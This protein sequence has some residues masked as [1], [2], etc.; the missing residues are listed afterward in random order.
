MSELY[1][2]TKLVEELAE[3]RA[4]EMMRAQSAPISF[5]DN[6]IRLS[7]LTGASGHTFE[8]SALLKEVKGWVAIGIGAVADRMSGLSLGAYA[9]GINGE[10]DELLPMQHR[11]N[12][13]MEDPNPIFSMPTMLG[14]SA[15]WLHLTGQA[16]FQVLHDGLG[17]PRELWPMPPDRVF[18]VPSK[19]NVIGGYVVIGASGAEI[20]METR[21]VVRV[22]RPDPKD[23]YQALGSLSPQATEFN[24]ERYRMGHVEKTYRNDATPRLVLESGEDAQLPTDLE[25]EAWGLKWREQYHRRSGRDQGVPAML[26]PGFKAHELGQTSDGA[27]TVDMGN[28]LRDQMLSSMGVPGSIVGLVQDVNRAAAETNQYTFDKNGVKPK[29][30]LFAG[31]MTQQLAPQFDPGI[32]YKFEEFLS[33]DKEFLLK[34]EDSDLRNKVR[35]PNEV[36]GS[37]G[38]DDA[39]WG[40]DPVGS[41]NDVPYT[42][43]DDSGMESVADL[44]G[45]PRQIP[46]IVSRSNDRA[47]TVTDSMRDGFSPERSWQRV[48]ANERKFVARFARGMSV[49]FKAQADAAVERF[50]K[51]H[52]VPRARVFADDLFIEGEFGELYLAEVQRV[53]ETIYV[54]NAIAAFGI[55]SSSAEFIFVDEQR[56]ILEA[57]HAEMVQNVDRVTKDRITRALVEGTGKGESVDQ[58]AKRISGAVI[59]RKRARTIARTE[60]GGAAQL[61]QIE[62]FA[63]SGVVDGKRWNTSFNN[64][65]D[66]HIAAHGQEVRLEELFL[67]G[68]ETASAPLSP[69][70]SAAQRANC[71][72]F[73]TPVFVDDGEGG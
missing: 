4:L 21:E 26:P 72:C 33:P 18:P 2:P 34:Q 63:Q 66:D 60:V 58:I 35:S 73:V 36:R 28:Q 49:V 32:V 65:R 54:D 29:T 51:A 67:V 50:M 31:A 15:Y 38:L 52:P 20:M 17:V 68:G 42:G 41:F 11:A 70:L 40:H 12:V 45:G 53:R 16:Y 7:T 8:Q 14:L 30:M 64:S 59:N 10:E 71:Q 22:W 1:L 24:A 23:L 61:G 56:R 3:E 62:S 43:E 13:I 55:L 37:R 19:D 6:Q 48:I 5:H 9:K 25:A 44:G 39:E 27:M 46:S 57:T 47:S 69:V